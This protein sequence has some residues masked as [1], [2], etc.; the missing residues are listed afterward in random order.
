MPVLC[1][2][3]AYAVPSNVRCRQFDGLPVWS[4]GTGVT[5]FMHG[6]INLGNLR[7]YLASWQ[8]MQ[9]AAA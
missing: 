9:Y 3:Y 1:A 4:A 8:Q 2:W 6:R 7:I 5:E